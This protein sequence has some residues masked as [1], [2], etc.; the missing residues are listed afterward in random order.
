VLAFK[1]SLYVKNDFELGT[2]FLQFKRCRRYINVN[3]V[4]LEKIIAN[5]I[6][7]KTICK[8]CPIYVGYFSMS[9]DAAEGVI[10]H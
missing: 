1:V 3:K 4:A 8:N 7:S 2:F 5:F 10:V 9:N 6:F